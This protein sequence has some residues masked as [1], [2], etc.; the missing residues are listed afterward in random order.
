[1]FPRMNI[2]NPFQ[3][4]AFGFPQ[5]GVGFGGINPM[6]PHQALPYPINP[7]A[8]L[9]GIGV[10]P[11]ALGQTQYVHPVLVAQIPTTNPALLPPHTQHSAIGQSPYGGWGNPF[12]QGIS[13]LLH[14]GWGQQFG[15]GI[16]QPGVPLSLHTFP[17][18]AFGYPAPQQVFGWGA[19]TPLNGPVLGVDPITGALIAQQ[20]SL[21]AQ[22]HLPIRPLITPHQP[23]AFQMAVWN[24][25]TQYGSPT[26]GI[27]F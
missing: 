3:T 21:L 10:N 13:P 2:T 11:Y 23:D 17:Q 24:A 26:A 9:S 25:A 16:G 8:G 12:S 6:V 5:Y 4:F 14:Q 27:P 15:G 20:S 1:M 19:P 7:I 18:Q 22:T